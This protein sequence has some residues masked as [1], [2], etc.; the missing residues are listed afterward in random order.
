MM[1]AIL[2]PVTLA[3]AGL[4]MDMTQVIQ[5]RS[6]LQDAADS[7][8]LSAAAAL[9]GNEQLTDAEA[10]AQAKLFMASQFTNINGTSDGNVD[11]TAQQ[12]SQAEVAEGAVASVQRTNGAGNGKTFDV[13]ISG[14]YDVSMNALTRLLGYDTMR[15]SVSSTSQSTTES[16][17]A[18]SMF[19]VL[20][21]SGSMADDTSTVNTAQPEKTVTY[22]CGTWREKKTCSY[23]QTNYY[24]K[25]EAL[26]LA[27]ADL[28]TQ[29]DTADP[30]K[31]YVRTAAVSYNASMQTATAFEWGTSKAL[32]YVK[33][34][35][36]T[37]G[38]DSSGAMKEAY[39]KVTA[40]SELTAHKTKN[41]QESPG[42]FIIF[43]TDG[44]NNYTSADTSTRATCT[45]A[46]AAA[47]EIYT[48][49][50]MAP[51]RGREL[52]QD[53]AT[54]T[55]HYY[56]ANNA[57]EL[58]AAFKEIGEKAAAAATRLTN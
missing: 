15:V 4:A 53:C 50:F 16:K 19:L 28:T 56:D 54:D 31:M 48:V 3:I 27:V 21:R 11:P 58:V 10:I 13:T 41:G 51:Q 2:L 29:L 25:I 40:A 36:A 42:K 38:T 7:A 32:T 5:V 34:L 45:S 26:K 49:A 47:V 37:G 33:A 23:T 9:A 8:A 30:D 55:S 44:D 22:D 57:A 39:T 14:H 43:M 46:K 1:T 35:T 24:T 20:D 6:A 17:N 52:L 12:Q 18:L